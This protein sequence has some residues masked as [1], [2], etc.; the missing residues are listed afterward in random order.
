MNTRSLALAT[1]SAFLLQAQAAQP[2]AYNLCLTPAAKKDLKVIT[3]GHVE[4]LSDLFNEVGIVTR[5]RITSQN[6]SPYRQAKIMY[7]MAAKPGGVT[8]ARKL[9]GVEGEK[10]I[11]EFVSCR[12]EMQ[13]DTN[14]TP[15][16]CI[17]RMEQVI[18]T[19]IK[20]NL[21]RRWLSHVDPIAGLAI[22][23][24]RR[25]MD[26]RP[27]TLINPLHAKFENLVREV[28]RRTSNITS[29]WGHGKSDPAT[30]ILFPEKVYPIEGKWR[31]T[32]NCLPEWA[33]KQV[34][35]QVERH[36]PNNYSADWFGE[37]VK[38]ELN[39][40]K[41]GFRFEL[42]NT[43]K[44]QVNFTHSRAMGT[45]ETRIRIDGRDVIKF[46]HIRNVEQLRSPFIPD[47]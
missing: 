37:R 10:V 11:D 24:S 38:L 47:C 27:I 30:H 44:G 45:G 2:S 35:V 29:F 8:D 36:G 17:K 39:S 3:Q 32:G 41:N 4:L 43:T 28:E 46:C 20:N 9:Y 14:L 33:P 22:D 42:L 13:Q 15:E 34:Y 6:R 26:N 21:H 12:A 1:V 5:V 31:V 25:S 18:K 16:D 19:K 7:D 40:I 23:L